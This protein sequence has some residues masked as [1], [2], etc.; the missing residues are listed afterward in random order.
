MSLTAFVKGSEQILGEAA[1]VIVAQVGER[2]DATD[3]TKIVEQLP[4]RR[5]QDV[6]VVLVFKREQAVRRAAE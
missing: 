3:L 1:Q 6:Y 5:D 4:T 2:L